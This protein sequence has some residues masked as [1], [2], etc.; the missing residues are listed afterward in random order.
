MAVAENREPSSHQP[1]S[2]F[3]WQFGGSCA[4]LHVGL[5]CSRRDQ[6]ACS[7]APRPARGLVAGMF[8]NRER[9]D[10]DLISDVVDLGS[11]SDNHRSSFDDLVFPGENAHGFL[12]ATVVLRRHLYPAMAAPGY[13]EWGRPKKSGRSTASAHLC[14]TRARER[15]SA[16]VALP[17]PRPLLAQG[18]DR[19][20]WSLGT[21][22]AKASGGQ[23]GG[24]IPD[25][26]MARAEPVLPRS[27]ERQSETIEST[28]LQAVS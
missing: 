23:D 1:S 8:K 22:G 6:G 18:D 21:R 2:R 24:R 9:R 26:T 12:S 4:S 3:A 20:L 14:K 28:N 7:C 27:V 15:C 10:V 17:T 16:H 25:L 5:P 19:H 11:W 13:S